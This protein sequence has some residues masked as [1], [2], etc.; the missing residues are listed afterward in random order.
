MYDLEEKATDITKKAVRGAAHTDDKVN[1]KSSK[2]APAKRVT[3]KKVAHNAKQGK[4]AKARHTAPEKKGP[5]KETRAQTR[6]QKDA[7]KRKQPEQA[8]EPEVSYQQPSVYQPG[9]GKKAAA[10][11]KQQRV[12]AGPGAKGTHSSMQ[13]PLPAVRPL[14]AS[15]SGKEME[16]PDIVIDLEKENMSFQLP[17]EAAMPCPLQHTAVSSSQ[18]STANSVE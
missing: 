8:V 11:C 18:G 16:E 4:G 14:L 9:Q 2:K 3:A 13:L 6:A 1:I 12:T 5:E 17:H 10:E 15:S 7:A